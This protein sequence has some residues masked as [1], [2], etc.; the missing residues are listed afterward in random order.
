M[1]ALRRSG[2]R[3]GVLVALAALVSVQSASAQSAAFLGGDRDP[4]AI[5]ALLGR[6]TPRRLRPVGT[7]SVTM[8]VDLGEPLDAAFKPRTR[9]HPRGFLA[10]IAAYRLSRLLDMDNVP[11][12]LGRRFPRPALR[13]RYEPE[14]DDPAWDRIQEAVL[15]DAPGFVRGAL[16]YW[17]PSMERTPLATLEGLDAV[18]ERWLRV[19]GT[20][21]AGEEPTARD[22][23]TLIAFDY[24][25]GNWDRFSGGNVSSDGH[26]RLFV[27]DHNVA[28][29]ASITE[30]RY[31]R[32][33]GHLERVE[34]F[35]RG[36][37]QAVRAL[38]RTALVQALEGDPLGAERPVLTVRQLD[39]LF[40]RR[41]ALLS[42]IGA[43]VSRH[44]AAAVL[45]WP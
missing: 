31:E 23:S 39:A 16:I 40:A 6:Q 11:P 36:F 7:T 8:R 13:D 42:Y 17:I 21:E 22:L 35:S 33:T 43:Q 34:R 12:A 27:R 4:D 24:L 28:F 1:R 30:A 37:V 10:E 26:G 15:W 14:D 18:S 41:R 32:L 19:G 2:V 38:T 45:P 9:A 3:S 20:L 25:I 5:V 44:G 29:G